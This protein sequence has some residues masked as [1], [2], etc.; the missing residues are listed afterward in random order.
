MVTITGV[1]MF[2]LS[3]P[4]LPWLCS[5]QAARDVVAEFANDNVKYL[6]LRTTPRANAKTG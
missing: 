6:E 5:V 3:V 4:T 2:L 1:R